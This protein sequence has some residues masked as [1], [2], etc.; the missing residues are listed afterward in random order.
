MFIDPS[1]INDQFGEKIEKK[2]RQGRIGLPRRRHRTSPFFA[3][4]LSQRPPCAGTHAQ[5]DRRCHF[6]LRVREQGKLA[7]SK[8]LERLPLEHASESY[9]RDAR[10]FPHNTAYYTVQRSPRCGHVYSRTGANILLNL[11][12]YLWHDD[13]AHHKRDG[14]VLVNDQLFVSRT[15]RATNQTCQ[16]SSS[17]SRSWLRQEQLLVSVLERHTV[18]RD[19]TQKKVRME[20]AHPNRY[21]LHKSNRPSRV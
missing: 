4:S 11:C 21:R 20:P 17:S 1:L 3:R 14:C 10:L 9:R 8:A 13:T 19:E 2:A 6:R 12:E 18:P 5:A 15:G 7:R 16:R